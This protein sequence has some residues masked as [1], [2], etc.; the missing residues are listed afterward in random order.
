MLEVVNVETFYGKTQALWDVSLSIGGKEIVALVGA[1]EAGKST[2]LNTIS[3]LLS[4]ASGHV[5]FLGKRI[6]GLAPDAVVDAILDR[7]AA[8]G[9]RP[10][11]P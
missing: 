2:L 6:D 8:A 11:T 4:P 3:G 5:E 9:P 1:N 7:I 10:A